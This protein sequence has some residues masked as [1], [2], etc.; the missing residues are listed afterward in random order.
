[1]NDKIEKS[2][3]REP[4]ALA[5]S[6]PPSGRRT[7]LRVI[8]PEDLPLI[9]QWW[10]EPEA[11]YLDGGDTGGPSYQFRNGF[12]NRV[13]QG[14]ETNWFV[15]ETLA[16]PPGPVGYLLYRTYP[17]E[18][19]SAE[20]AVRLSRSSWGMGYGSEAFGLFIDHLFR[21][22]GFQQI[23]LTVYIFNPRAIRIYEKAG[24]R[25]EATFAD[26]KGLELL[27]MTLTRSEY[28]RKRRC[29]N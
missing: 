14:R 20:V 12:K 18:Q 6:A 4:R 8:T 26:E 5:P 19:N 10:E 28:E 13:L 1:M 24:F 17:E 25:E 16:T 2:A 11:N 27:K 7:H 29:Q 15:I 23:W 9:E 22:L 3:V 21:V